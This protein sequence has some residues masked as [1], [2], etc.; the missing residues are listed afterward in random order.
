MNNP[1]A[2]TE[3]LIERMRVIHKDCVAKAATASTTTYRWYWEAEARKYA[4][5]ITESIEMLNE[6]AI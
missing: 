1:N 6:E 2:E 3:A 5:R 4:K